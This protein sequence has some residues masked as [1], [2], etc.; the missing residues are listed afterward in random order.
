MDLVYAAVAGLTSPVWGYRLF[1][2]GKWRTD[3][4]GRWGRVSGL[5]R[6]GDGRPTLLIHAVSVGEVNAVSRLVTR[7]HEATGGGWRIVVSATTDTGFAR[8]RQLFSDIHP[9]VRYPLDFSGC[10]NRFLD[11]VSPDLVALTELEVWPNFV[12]A[13]GRRGVP[14]GVI[15]GRLSARS[16]ER[17]RRIRAL[18]RPAFARLAGVLV[19]SQQY[20]ERFVAL[21]VTADRVTVVDSMKWDAAPGPAPGSDSHSAGVD[22]DAQHLRTPGA[23]DP[24]AGA[25]ELAA[26][27]GIDRSQPVV[28]AGSTGPG[29]EK[30]LMA[31]CPAG[32]QLVLVPRK[33]ERFDEVAS[34]DPD[35][36]RRS[37]HPDAGNRPDKPAR[38]FL[39]DTMGELS[40]AYSLADVAVVGRSFMGDLYGSNPLEPIA[41]GKP[42]IIGPHYGDFSEM[43]EALRGAGGIVVT[44]HPGRAISE[45]LEDRQAAG[46]LARRGGEVIVSRR[47]AT[48]RHVRWLMKMMPSR[49]GGL[50]TEN[51]KVEPVGT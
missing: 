50:S 9:V 37:R 39:V 42:T 8:A 19:Q 4:A 38:V 30:M 17:Y 41:L 10:V 5:N 49:A 18:V 40:K 29:E 28:V 3:W 15:N 14:V 48:E 27:M 43:V 32:A 35:M 13:C 36:V 24:V 6:D 33:P 44:D 22:A 31:S 20:A 46:A 2:S 51:G 26:A 12:E 23:G 1:R 7:L 25:H 47:G 16:F 34:L 21:G 45:L 11:A